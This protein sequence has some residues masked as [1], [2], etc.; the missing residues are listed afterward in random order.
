MNPGDSGW[1]D[2]YLSVDGED[3]TFFD[4]SGDPRGFSD[5]RL[6]EIARDIIAEAGEI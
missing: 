6:I 5:S 4:V 1:E 3:W 2:F